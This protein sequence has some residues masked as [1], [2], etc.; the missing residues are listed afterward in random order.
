MW[1]DSFPGEGSTFWFTIPLKFGRNRMIAG[2]ELDGAPKQKLDLTG[3][4]LLVVEDVDTNYF[5]ISSLLGKLNGK[6]IRATN[7]IKAIEMTRN[8]PSINMILMD[9][10]LPVMDGYT[11]TREIKKIRP[12]LPVIAQ[13]AFAMMGE[14]ER[15][16]EAGCD[17]YISKPIRKETL[18]EIISRFL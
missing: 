16:Q 5:Y 7:G 17:E 4:C 8:N 11:A 1:I 2:D 18:L 3:K 13:T 10:E 12:E 9:I 15:S 14:R 6:V